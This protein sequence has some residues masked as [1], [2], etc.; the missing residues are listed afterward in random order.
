M[1]TIKHYLYGFLAL[2]IGL[3]VIVFRKRGTDLHKAQVMLLAQRV[4]GEQLKL[5]DNVRNAL[6]QYYEA[7]KDYANA[8]KEKK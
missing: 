2:L 7:K 3:A 6:I 4:N 5:D 8:L 1:N